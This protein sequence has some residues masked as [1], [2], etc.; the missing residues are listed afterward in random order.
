VMRMV[1]VLEDGWEAGGEGVG[2]EV[3]RC[4]PYVVKMSKSG[5]L[6]RRIDRDQ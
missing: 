1:G 5:K 3:K 6:Y 4:S 2:G